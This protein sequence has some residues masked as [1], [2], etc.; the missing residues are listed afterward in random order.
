MTA[1]HHSPLRITLKD[2]E[3]A[4]SLMSRMAAIGGTSA[5][6]FG[7][8]IGIP[9]R[10]ILK[11]DASAVNRLAQ[12]GGLNAEPLLSWTPQVRSRTQR[13]IRGHLFPGNSTPSSKIRGCPLC[14]Q[15]D[16]KHANG[17]LYQAMAIRGDW[18]IPHV[19]ICL[20]H[21]HSL[22]PLWQEVRPY[23]RY[24]T[25]SQF[26]EIA[27]N[28]VAD[29]YTG[30]FREPTDFDEWFDAR[31]MNYQGSS[32]L[33]QF[34]LNVS[35]TFCRLM[36]SALMRREG[37]SA[38]FVTPGSKWAL[39]QMGFEVAQ[40]G[41]EAIKDALCELNRL[42][43]PNHGPKSVFPMLYER[44]AFEYRNDPDYAPF[45][46]IL[47]THLSETWPLGP[48]DE[49]LGE[50]ITERRLHSVRTASQ[51]FGVDPR[52]LR[53]MLAASGLID[54]SLHDSWAVFDAQKAQEMIESLVGYET[55]KGFAEG[56]S[57]S[58]SQFD[59]LVEDG[60]LRPAL[61]E[62]RTKH[63]WNP[64]DGQIFLKNILS[65]AT[66]LHRAH[67]EWEHI[68]K[69]AQRLKVRPGD[70]I[71]AIWDG[72]I[73]QVGNRIHF[74]GYDAIYVNHA[75]V[76]SILIHDE[77]T[78]LSI[79]HFSKGVGLAQP[80]HLNRLIKN[81]H[82][83]ATE[84]RNPKTKALQ[85]FITNDDA[86]SFHAKFVTLRTLAKDRETSWQ[87]VFGK[88]RAQGVAPFSPDGVDYG[89]IYL[90]SDVDTAVT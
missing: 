43:E 52:R 2:R 23:S 57:M 47:A 20:R 15:D 70:I 50:P 79:E 89:N 13:L 17:P 75:E 71:R 1:T 34:P 36:G 4:F 6:D 16:A 76:M 69:S 19:N 8:D 32:W 12:I 28:I 5:P 14:L 7:L 40:N 65:G 58:R 56:I 3:T 22:V 48:E 67:P 37:I 25:V 74:S 11:G 33:D 18:L 27:S 68:S 88:M 54:N 30:D 61:K 62:A 44:L 45:A 59:L 60:I 84:F 83:T 39:Y 35:A 29:D 82:T 31:L 77:P 64:R 24:D 81:G 73:K 63:V 53:K 87:N 78:G 90:R 38:R 41:P 55:A 49:L 46:K 10:D 9:F 42:A 86:K 26:S 51:E 80:V 85:L 66:K 21:E 72:L